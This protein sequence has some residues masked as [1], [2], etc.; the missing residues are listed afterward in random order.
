M[1]TAKDDKN[2]PV[3]SLVP[4]EL[5]YSV[6]GVRKYGTDKYHDPNNWKQV[7]TQR[8]WE[9]TI[10]HIVAAWNDYTAIDPESGLMHIEH[11]ACDLAF[12][13]QQIKGGNDGNTDGTE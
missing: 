12:M 1:G 6:A 10:R 11:A 5:I 7:E 4:P 3:L 8:Y 13:L 9:A 2:K